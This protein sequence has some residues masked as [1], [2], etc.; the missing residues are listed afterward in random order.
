M[1]GV[2][3]WRVGVVIP[4]HDEEATIATCVRSVARALEA[5][6]SRIEESVIVVVA[7]SCRDA[8]AARARTALRSAIVLEVAAATA[9]RA[10]AVGCEAAMRVLGGPAERTWIANTDADSAVGTT[11]VLR[12]LRA[13]AAGVTCITGIV[14]LVDADPRLRRSFRRTYAERIRRRDH[15]HVHGANLGVRADVLRRVGNWSAVETGEDHEL[16]RQIRASGEPCLTDPGLVVST[17]ARTVGRA[18]AGFARDLHRLSPVD[19]A[20]R[21]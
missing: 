16:W 6:H 15:D 14:D 10:R 12:Q 3:E 21:P 4:A 13:A 5:A 11:W 2:P 20:G 17:S 19:L 1:N 18:P 8:T 9:G 7:D